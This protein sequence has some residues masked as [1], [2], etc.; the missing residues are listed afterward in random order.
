MK[1]VLIVLM[2][3]GVIGCVSLGH[4]DRLRTENRQNLLKLHIGMTKQEVLDIMGYNS[5]KDLYA[6][7]EKVTVTNPYKSEIL[8]GKDKTLEVIYYCTDTKHQTKVDSWGWSLPSP[9]SDDELTPLI[10]DNNKLI[11]WG[12]SFLDNNVQKYELRLR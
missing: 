3:L 6:N 8:Q 1:K 10:F 9:I 11:G 12:W 7:Y 2:C 4:I 5:A